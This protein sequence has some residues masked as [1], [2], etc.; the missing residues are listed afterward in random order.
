M[1][2]CGCCIQRTDSVPTQAVCMDFYLDYSVSNFLQPTQRML[3]ITSTYGRAHRLHTDLD[4]SQKRNW[5]KV[6]GSSCKRTQYPILSDVCILIR[7]W[8]NKPKYC[9]KMKGTIPSI[10]MV[11]SLI[12]RNG[13]NGKYFGRNSG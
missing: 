10:K 9:E 5:V 1:K 13:R 2:I 4:L 6:K 12:N 8:L 3:C 11:N 7:F